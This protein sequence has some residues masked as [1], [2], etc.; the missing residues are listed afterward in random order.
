M[1]VNTLQPDNSVSMPTRF[2]MDL[3]AY[4]LLNANDLCALL[5]ERPAGLA[6]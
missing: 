2:G 5:R 6:R 4:Q 1:F 3:C